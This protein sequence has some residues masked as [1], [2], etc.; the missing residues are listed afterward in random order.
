MSR[1]HHER[2]NRIITCIWFMST[3]IFD[4]KMLLYLISLNWNVCDIKHRYNSSIFDPTEKRPTMQ[5]LPLS[6]SFHLFRRLILF[7]RRFFVLVLFVSTRFC[8]VHF[9]YSARWRER[10]PRFNMHDLRV[11]ALSEQKSSRRYDTEGANK[12]V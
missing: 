4:E 2:I 12:D 1:L 3:V 10:W 9:E 6:L 7:V 11:N 5:S 8:S